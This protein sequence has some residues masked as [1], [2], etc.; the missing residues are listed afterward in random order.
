[1][2]SYV[3]PQHEERLAALVRQINPSLTV[4]CSAQVC[5][6]FRE[7]ERCSTT[8]LAAYMQPVVASY[9]D[10]FSAT[11]KAA[12]YDGRFS[13]MQSNGGRLS[14]VQSGG[15]CLPDCKQSGGP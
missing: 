14:F 3:N 9:L 12:G 4:T 7:Y 5:R 15:P 13:I 10:R 11:L 8:A 6:E 2:N 1:M